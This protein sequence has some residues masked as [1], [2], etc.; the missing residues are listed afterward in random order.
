MRHQAAT[1]SETREPKAKVG[2]MQSARLISERPVEE[3]SHGGG[4]MTPNAS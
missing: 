2:G 4:L 1:S 3:G